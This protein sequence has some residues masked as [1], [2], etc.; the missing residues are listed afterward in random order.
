MRLLIAD[1]GPHSAYR[2]SRERHLLIAIRKGLNIVAIRTI[3]SRN[4]LVDLHAG[5]SLSYWRF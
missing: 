1:H 3:T 2:Q 4:V 5:H